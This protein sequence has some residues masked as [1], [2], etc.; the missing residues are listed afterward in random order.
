MP[1]DS[2]K[3]FGFAVDEFSALVR[4]TKCDVCDTELFVATPLSQSAQNLDGISHSNA[5]GAFEVCV[6]LSRD[7]KDQFPSK[8]F[9]NFGLPGI[10][11]FSHDP[12][13]AVGYLDIAYLFTYLFI[14]LF[15]YLSVYW[16][17]GFFF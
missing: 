17:I 6:E 13:S 9:E 4:T 14:Y 8:S 16:F 1:S 7:S 11:V 15:I 3:Y 12:Y 10:S 2:E 5:L